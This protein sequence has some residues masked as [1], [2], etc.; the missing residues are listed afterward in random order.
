MGAVLEE[1]VFSIR[2][3]VPKKVKK[4][5]VWIKCKVENNE[6]NNKMFLP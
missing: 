5:G 3:R 4:I 6:E 2:E 1:H